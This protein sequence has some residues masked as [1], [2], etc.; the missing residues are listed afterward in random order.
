MTF[1]GESACWYNA[2][3]KG[4]VTYEVLCNTED[5]L[6]NDFTIDYTNRCHPTFTFEHWAGCPQVYAGSLLNSG[7]SGYPYLF[8]IFF[9]FFILIGPVINFF[10]KRFFK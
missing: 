1:E 4:S 6:A 3:D 9:V 2:S 8:A 5:E 7:E 10:G